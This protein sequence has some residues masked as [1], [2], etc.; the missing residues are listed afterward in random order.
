M[1]AS[2]ARESYSLRGLPTKDSK[3]SI[4]CSTSFRVERPCSS[5]GTTASSPSGSRTERRFRLERENSI[6]VLLASLFWR[7]DT[8]A[9]P[10]MGQ[11]KKSTHCHSERSEESHPLRAFLRLAPT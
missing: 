9:K 3:R 6:E 2:R 4:A 5:L 1:I 10:C 8:G 11:E 7:L